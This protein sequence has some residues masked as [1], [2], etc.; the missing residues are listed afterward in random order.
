[1]RGE[2]DEKKQEERHVYRRCHDCGIKIHI[3][4]IRCPKCGKQLENMLY[5]SHNPEDLIYH[6]NLNSAKKCIEC[7]IRNTKKVSSLCE[8]IYCFATGRGKC[9]SCRQFDIVRFDCCQR[10]QKEG[11]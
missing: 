10:A 7:W 11:W 2:G 3:D 9:D 4:L 1:M 6:I 8:K 5:E